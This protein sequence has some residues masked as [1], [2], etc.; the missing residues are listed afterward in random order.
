[1]PEP[2]LTTGESIRHMFHASAVAVVGASAN[3]RKYGYMTLESLLKG[4]YRGRIYPVNP[5]GGE[6]LGLKTY[7]SLKDLPEVPGVAVLLVPVALVPRIIEEAADAG[8]PGVVITSAGFSETGR[9]DL[10]EEIL[11]I[12]RD[13]NIRIIGPNVEGFIYMP[14]RLHAQF[15]PVIRHCGPL[16]TI[17]QS[18]SLTNGLIGWANDGGVG[19][20]ACIN[21]GNQ[22]DICESD[23]L[24]YLAGDSHTRA[25]AMHIEGVKDGRRFVQTLSR[26]AGKKP[27]VIL[28]AGRS[29]AGKRSVASHTASLAGSHALFGALCR[30]FGA[31][32]VSDT[33][34]L[35]ETGTA[36]ALM[37]I[38]RG[39]RVV[40]IS[41]SGG[42]GVAAADEAESQGIEVPQL[43]AGLIRDLSQL[44]FANPLGSVANPIDLASMWAE[45]FEQTALLI[46]A[47]D[48][49]DVVLFNFGDPIA[50]GAEMLI[51]L[52]RKIKTPVVVS[53]MG[54]EDDQKRDVPL[55]QQ[56]G[57]PVLDTPES[58]V[59]CIAA[60]VRFADGRRSR[61]HLPR[62]DYLL[63]GRQAPR[64]EAG[65]MTEPEAVALLNRF[66]IPYPRHRVT[67]APSE[68]VDFADRN[69]YPLVLK[70]VS[71]DIPHKSDAGGVAANLHDARAV[72]LAYQGMMRKIGETA[73]GAAVEGVLACRQAAP[74]P[75]V[76]VG[77]VNDPVFGPAVMFGLGGVFVEILNDVS[78]RVAPLRRLDAEQMIREVKGFP[79]IRGARGQAGGNVTLLADLLLKV[80]EMIIAHPEIQELD[81][82]PVRLYPESLTA[83]DA[84]ILT[85]R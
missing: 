1:M 78:F 3:P 14:N 17:T 59:R 27:L 51:R 26:Q 61:A 34:S 46:D 12:A 23:F 43:P 82:N 13:R 7:P 73:P 52:S 9:D 69:G 35:Y 56:A 5:K 21:L 29:E 57:I 66:Q 22:V 11:C 55:L 70:I 44:E 54:G 19:I 81:L 49:G 65:F 71:K 36:L 28:K 8:I 68:A 2:E 25:V 60:A 6:I 83:L 37:A 58:A 76:V 31:I 16:A 42:L 39:N 63:S 80:S 32:P 33:R 77:A 64:G 30:Q 62:V 40:V 41:S 18:G 85:R 45:E 15:F 84:R 47:Y 20:S 4:G 72:E 50:G 24:E 10:Q 79:L 67:R 74:G 48:A 53:Y 38:P 75:E